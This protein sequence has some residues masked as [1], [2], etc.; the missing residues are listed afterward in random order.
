MRNHITHVSKE[1]FLPAFF[2]AYYTKSITPENARAGFKATGLVPFDLKAVLSELDVPIIASTPSP[3]P[4]L[5]A[6]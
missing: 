4:E 5:P 1:D 2:E 6:N 3:E